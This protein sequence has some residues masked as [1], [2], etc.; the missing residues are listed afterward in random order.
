MWIIYVILAFL[1]LS[2][3]AKVQE[4]NSQ[5][6]EK[7]ERENRIR[8]NVQTGAFDC[9]KEIF[10]NLYIINTGGCCC[11]RFDFRVEKQA[12]LIK[13]AELLCHKNLMLLETSRD[14]ML[15]RL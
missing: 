6:K 1:L 8:K 5:K 4:Y 14:I 13:Q 12:F 7:E 3:I 15:L 11:N 2:I 9:K 10:H